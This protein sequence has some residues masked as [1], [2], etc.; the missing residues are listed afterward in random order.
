M[1]PKTHFTS[2]E[3]LYD[4]LDHESLFEDEG[5]TAILEDDDLALL[6]PKITPVKKP[7]KKAAEKAKPKKKRRG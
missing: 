4:S 1:G 3:D 7:A 2:L 6:T 5:T